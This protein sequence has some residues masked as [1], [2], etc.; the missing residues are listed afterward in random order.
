MGDPAFPFLFRTKARRGEALRVTFPMPAPNANAIGLRRVRGLLRWVHCRTAPLRVECNSATISLP[1]NCSPPL[2]S[3]VHSAFPTGILTSAAGLTGPALNYHVQL[4]FPTEK[5]QPEKRRRHFQFLP[6]IALPQFAQLGYL[7]LTHWNLESAL[8][9]KPS[10]FVDALVQRLNEG[11]YLHG[12]A[13]QFF[14]PS[15]GDYLRRHR[16]HAILIVGYNS[17]KRTFQVALYSEGVFGIGDVSARLLRH[18]FQTA[19][20]G[21]RPGPRGPVLELI[22]P[23]PAMPA[24][25]CRTSAYHQ[26]RQYL[27]GKNNID[28]YG[29]GGEFFLAGS[30]TPRATDA[31]SFGIETYRAVAEYLT[32][33]AQFGERLDFR[34]TRT[35]MEHKLL[36]QNLLLAVATTDGQRRLAVTFNS[37]VSMASRFHVRAFALDREKVR[38]DL[39]SL[40]PELEAMRAKE[41]DLLEQFVIAQN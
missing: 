19:N 16:V 21:L 20:Y 28:E 11:K 26:L 29:P 9:A 30:Y 10:D 23:N 24:T 3:Y 7:K 15:S 36:L 4:F 27:E 35:I 33:I 14:I 8:A 34:V 22:T 37:V 1:F 18:S 25:V 41:H 17:L 12:W 13:N 5:L 38:G 32:S 39:R 31:G 2:R 6:G 40:I